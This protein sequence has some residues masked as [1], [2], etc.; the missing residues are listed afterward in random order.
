MLG[1]WFTGIQYAIQWDQSYRTGDS[2]APTK[3]MHCGTLAQDHSR[4]VS[5][6][7]LPEG[8]CFYASCFSPVCFWLHIS[9]KFRVV[10]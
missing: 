8:H 3:L 9:L 1:K 10:S 6:S 7:R 4:V 5:Y 2:T